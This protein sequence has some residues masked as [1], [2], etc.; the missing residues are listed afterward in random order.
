MEKNAK[1]YVAGHAG[2]TGSAIVRK[3]RE[4]G[5]ENII[6]ERSA[7]LDLTVQ[8]K[9]NSYFDIQK[10]DY[11]IITAA[12]VGGIQANCTQPAEFIYK[13]I[14]IEANLIEASY[15]H[16]VKKLLLTGSGC[17][18]PRI[19][20]QPIKEEYLLTGE[21]EKTNEAY[22][23]AK[24]CGLKLCEYYNKQY[25]TNYISTMPCNLYGEGD[26]FNPVTSHVVP[27]MIRKFH[28]AKINNSPCVT[29]WGTGTAMREFLHVDDLAD[30]SV[31]L[32]ENYDGGG[33]LNVGCGEDIKVSELAQ[34]IKEV[35]GYD[36]EIVYDPSKPDGTPRKLLDS[37]KLF[38][39]GWRP[40]IS[41]REG[42][43]RTYKD[44]L[45]NGS[46]YRM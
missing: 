45:E 14:M 46:K 25:G 27:A 32:M 7:S 22:A 44:Y 12:K 28:E 40:R 20:Q 24:I 41:L 21:L 18:Y 38:A 23:L 37:S 35:V 42:L 2:L 6:G 33:W 15:T 31:F 26:N 36:G 29:L 30:A 5:Y 39:L 16:D 11:V 19:V 43:E 4:R 17:V 8:S 1:I 9:V 3:L 10:P 13:N 34:I